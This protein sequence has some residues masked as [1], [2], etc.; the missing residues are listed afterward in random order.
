[1]T[2]T[3]TTI[4]LIDNTSGQDNVVFLPKLKV[5]L[6]YMQVHVVTC[7]TARQVMDLQQPI[8]GIIMSGGPSLLTEKTCPDKFMANCTALSVY[9]DVPVFGICFGMQ[10]MVKLYGGT[11]KRLESRREG[12]Q[13]LII[14]NETPKVTCYSS[15]FIDATQVMP[16]GFHVT[17]TTGDGLPAIIE[18]TPDRRIP[19][20]ACQ[21]HPEDSGEHGFNLLYRFVEL[22]ASFETPDKQSRQ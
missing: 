12:K 16:V 2:T 5:A 3:T 22:C 21:Y 7:S 15:M 17:A 20:V 14:P 6:E 1:M 13:T 18:T 10:L 19:M 4:L 8:D 9:P 11:L